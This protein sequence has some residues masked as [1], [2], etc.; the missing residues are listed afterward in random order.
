MRDQ[1]RACPRLPDLGEPAGATED[2]AAALP[3]AFGR[4]DPQ[5]SHSRRLAR[6]R[7]IAGEAL[8]VRAAI[9]TQ[10]PIVYQDWS[11]D[12]G[13]DVRV[14]LGSEQQAM[15][16][17]F[18]GSVKV[19]SGEREVHD[20]QLALLGAGDCVR[21]RA[22]TG[23]GASAFARGRPVARAGSALRPVRDEHR[24][25]DRRPRC[26]ISSPDKMGEITRTAK[27]G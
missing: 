8:G 5:R 3:G 15:V 27:V 25:R 17:V 11:L 7:V 13:A 10:T 1:R 2:D 26:A 9:E 22:A 16:Y 21:L 18:Q 6:V 23:A 20:G 14:A 19:G 4:E 24:A 12:P